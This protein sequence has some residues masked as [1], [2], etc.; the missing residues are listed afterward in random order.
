MTATA[1]RGIRGRP[2]R[3]I[4]AR[5]RDVARKIGA[6]G[7][8]VKTLGRTGAPVTH[9]GV[10]QLAGV[11]RTFT[12]END[13]GGEQFDLPGL[14]TLLRRALDADV[15]A[16]GVQRMSGGNSSGAWRL[17]ARVPGAERLMVLKAPDH[18]SVVHRRDVGGEGR[19][20]QAIHVAGGPVPAV[21]AI[22][23]EGTAIGRPCIVMEMVDGRAV[24]DG[25]VP[26]GEP[27]WFRGGTG[28]DRRTA[29]RSFYDALAALHRIDAARVPDDAVLAGGVEQ[30]RSGPARRGGGVGPL[31][32]SHRPFRRRHRLLEGVRRDGTHHYVHSL[33]AHVGLRRTGPARGA[34]PLDRKLGGLDRGGILLTAR[35]LMFIF[36]D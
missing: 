20:L 25:A 27:D 32:G 3:A 5:R 8:A 14:T 21:I 31:V 16:L 28:E 29:R 10:A 33:A 15:A 26:D 18:T 22:D 9:A 19:F 30:C 36:M 35:I 2:E 17:E 1:G 6:V 11:S 24:P 4:A 13:E 7:K 12:Y 34:Q 23:E